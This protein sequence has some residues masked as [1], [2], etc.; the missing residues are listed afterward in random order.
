[1][2]CALITALPGFSSNAP[3]HLAT[4]KGRAGLSA[5]RRNYRSVST[6]QCVKLSCEIS[7]VGMPALQTNLVSLNSG[8]PSR[9][10][11]R[12]VIRSL[13]WTDLFLSPSPE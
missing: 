8:F 3:G 12:F 2:I 13:N 5:I 6:V 7:Q 9:L 10:L 11:A 4:M 1:M